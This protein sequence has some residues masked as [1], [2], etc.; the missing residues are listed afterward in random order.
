MINVLHDV[1]LRDV[2]V[3]GSF[4]KQEGKGGVACTF[5]Y[6]YKLHVTKYHSSGQLNGSHIRKRKQGKSVK[7]QFKLL[8]D[9]STKSLSGTIR[10]SGKAR[11]PRQ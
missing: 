8:P 3:A 2:E 10:D 11:L 4:T 7:S 9:Q 1:N 6:Y 5:E